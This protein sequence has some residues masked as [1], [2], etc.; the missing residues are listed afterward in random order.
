MITARKP[1]SLQD[2]RALSGASDFSASA[3][4]ARSFGPLPEPGGNARGQPVSQ[5]ARQHDQLATMVTLVRHEV[6]EKVYEVRREVLPGGSGNCA[7]ASDTESDQS[8]D[9]LAAPR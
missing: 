9:A 5:L 2:H 7:A 1:A 8:S 4:F 6:A 3:T